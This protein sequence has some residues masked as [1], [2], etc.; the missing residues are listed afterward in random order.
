MI[1]RIGVQK[2]QKFTQYHGINNLTDTRQGVLIFW[3]CFIQACIIDTHA[4]GSI[5]LFYENKVC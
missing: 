3:T 5:R 4:L 1:A 2:W